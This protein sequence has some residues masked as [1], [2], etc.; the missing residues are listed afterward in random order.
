[1]GEMC[2]LGSW[3]S[4]EGELREAG[5]VKAASWKGGRQAEIGP[6]GAVREEVAS[7]VKGSWAAHLES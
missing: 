6:A 7:G 2:G 4:E 3:T 1:M 5:A